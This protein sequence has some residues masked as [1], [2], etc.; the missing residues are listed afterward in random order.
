[1]DV[2]KKD[3]NKLI[4][5]ILL[6]V[7]IV[8]AIV[9]VILQINATRDGQNNA[10]NNPT[11]LEPVDLP[12]IPV[13]T[14]YIVLSYPAE[15]EGEV[16]VA[17]Q[18]TDNGQTIHFITDFTGDELELFR[19]SI[20]KDVADGYQLGVLEDEELGSL[21]VCVSVKEYTNGTFKPEEYNK[22]NMLQGYVNEIIVQ[23]Y[24][25][26]RFVPNK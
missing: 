13:P 11:Y 7:L 2:T 24:A 23:F 10:A 20:G 26:S 8:L 16:K 19:F 9:L 22:L 1:M 3:K 12:A 6:G 17:Y 21:N 4:C 15:L 5:A 25:D 18:E 14:K